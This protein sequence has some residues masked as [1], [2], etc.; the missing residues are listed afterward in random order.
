VK[1]NRWQLAAVGLVLSLEG[2]FCGS[3]SAQNLLGNPSFESPLAPVATNWTIKYLLGCPDDFAIKD[4]TTS[5]SL[6]NRAAQ[7]NDRGLHFRPSNEKIMHA[8]ATQTVS[9]LQAGHTYTITGRVW[10]ESPGFSGASGIYRVYFEAIGGQGTARSPDAPV[11][12]GSSREIYSITQTPDANG[13]IEVR[14]HMDKFDWCNYDKC[15]VINGYF[16]DFSLVY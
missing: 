7:N 9:G 10:G 13:K 5:A 6:F 4:R 8:Y 16:D 11:D 1:A 2:V 15:V 3:A 14:L 12:P